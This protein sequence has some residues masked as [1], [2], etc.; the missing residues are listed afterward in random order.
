MLGFGKIYPE[1]L[2]Y[3]YKNDPFGASISIGASKEFKMWT[4]K[5]VK[6]I[7]ETELII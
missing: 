1:L 3:S 4:L 2:G 7:C 6:V 5:N